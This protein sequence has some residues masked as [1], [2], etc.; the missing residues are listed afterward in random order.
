MDFDA[1]C[2]RAAF[3]ESSTDIREM[4]SFAY[5][6]QVLSS[7][8]VYSAHFYGSMLWDLTSESAGQV[9]RSWN[10]CV[11]L[12]WDV[13]RWTHNYLVDNLLGGDL[14]PVKKKLMCQYVN[15][16]QKLRKSPLREVRILA[17]LAGRDRQSVT[18]KN[19]AML[20]GEFGLDPWSQG[21]NIFKSK[22]KG[23]IIP[24]ADTWRLPLLQRLLNQRRDMVACDEEVEHITELIDCLCTT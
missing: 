5:P 23:Y 9:F 13:P 11:K 22:F 2:K 14:P 10:T 12:A 16:F 6:A 20:E 1:K 18:G 8:S 3:I 24:D 19:L 15:F 7:V 4:F 17:S 21:V